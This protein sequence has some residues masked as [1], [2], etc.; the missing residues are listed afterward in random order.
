K[1]CEK[2]SADVWRHILPRGISGDPSNLVLLLFVLVMSGCSRG[3]VSGRTT[4]TVGSPGYPSYV[5]SHWHAVGSRSGGLA[6]TLSNTLPNTRAGDLFLVWID[7]DCGP[8]DHID[9]QCT[10]PRTFQAIYDDINNQ[11]L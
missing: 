5:Q 4:P 2:W 11:Y 8:E 1:C 10:P 7:W 6:N 9:V 3:H